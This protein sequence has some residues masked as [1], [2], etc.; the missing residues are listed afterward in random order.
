MRRVWLIARKDMKEGFGQRALL[1]R[2]LL[3]AMLLP[4]FYGVM[5]GIMLQRGQVSPQQARFLAGQISLFAALAALLGTLPGTVI[6]A[7]AIALERVARTIESLLAT[8]VTDKEIFAGKVLGAYLPG[9]VGGYGAGALY[10]LS[11]S[12]IVGIQPLLLPKVTFVVYYILLMLPIVVAIETT[13]SVM[14]S[15]RCGTV[16]AA[17][18]LSAL[19]GMPIIGGV[20]YV[21]YRAAA[22]P[23]WQ[24]LLLA[25]GL[26]TLV[27]VL[28]HLGARALGREEIMARLD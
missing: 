4:V 26:L 14:I 2:T 13:V 9:L 10:F 18:Q 5:T 27:V 7:G 6:A 17:S 20:V 23:L 8:P 15:A 22:W 11:A 28:L 16:M 24:L 12:A 25:A 3:P 19:I 21:G 1:L